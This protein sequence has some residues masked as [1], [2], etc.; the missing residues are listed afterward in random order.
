MYEVLV[1]DCDGYYYVFESIFV[2][3]FDSKYGV[4]V[5]IVVFLED[6]VFNCFEFVEDGLYCNGYDVV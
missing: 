5:F 3:I 2:F 4:E 1:F 6:Y